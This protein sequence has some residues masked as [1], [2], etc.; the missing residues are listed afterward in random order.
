WKSIH[1]LTEYVNGSKDIGVENIAHDEEVCRFTFIGKTLA[2]LVNSN[3]E[4]RPFVEEVLN[5]KIPFELALTTA[6]TSQNAI[7][8]EEKTVNRTTM[9]SPQS[10][11]HADWP[12]S[13]QQ[14]QTSP[15]LPS[16]LFLQWVCSATS[17][18]FPLR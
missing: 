2:N 1:F 14:V 13:A 3:G 4:I 7:A 11:G 10:V 12:C 18:S 16:S 8:K 17:E 6:S 9:H 15:A 5:R